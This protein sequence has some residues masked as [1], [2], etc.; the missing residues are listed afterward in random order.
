MQMTDT[1]SG[2]LLGYDEAGRDRG[3]AGKQFEP[4]RRQPGTGRTSR[5]L[6]GSHQRGV[7]ARAARRSCSS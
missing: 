5:L 2:R 7:G 1:C 6:V 4:G 3:A